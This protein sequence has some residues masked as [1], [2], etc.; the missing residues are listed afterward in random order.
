MTAK[1]FLRQ[2]GDCE[3]RIQSRLR[4]IQRLKEQAD[5]I[6]V[7]LSERVQSSGSGDS[8]A[9]I[10]DTYID[11]ENEL[12][13]EVLHLKKIQQ[14]IKTA[15]NSLSDSKLKIVLETIYLDDTS[16]ECK[17]RGVDKWDIASERTHYCR[18]QIFRVHGKALIAIKDVTEC[19]LSSM[20]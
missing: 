13:E 2:Y 18:R 11:M 20:I 15:I 1:E 9:K 17:K 16:E 10:I 12:K 4:R 3:K 8:Q 19:H 14:Q 5:D 6:S 7:T